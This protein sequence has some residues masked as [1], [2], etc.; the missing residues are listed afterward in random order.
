M[1]LLFVD[2]EEMVLRGIENG[3]VFGPDD[4]EADFVTSAELAYAAM[5]ATAY[6][7]LVTDMKMPALT[8]ADV[9]EFAMANRPSMMRIVLSGEIDP[10]LAVRA[11]PLTHQFVSKPCDPDDLFAIIEDAYGRAQQLEEGTVRDALSRLDR[12]PSQPELFCKIRECIDRSAGAGAVAQ[13]IETDLAVAAAVLRTANS[14]FYGFRSPAVTV[15]EAVARL[16]SGT[17]S[18]I[19]LNAELSAWAPPEMTAAVELLNRH[20]AMVA[21]AVREM[22]PAEYS[23][24]S[25][26]ALLHDVGILVVLSQFPDEFKQ[27]RSVLMVHSAANELEERAMFGATHGEIGAYV[28]EMWNADPVIVSVAMHHHHPAEVDGRTRVILDAIAAADFV[29]H[30]GDEPPL[31]VPAELI[32]EAERVFEVET[33]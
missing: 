24:A 18:G 14:A 17:I 22:L 29:S 16:G 3:L 9:L 25:L 6:D 1:R 27:L 23:E 4:W 20:S 30:G 10:D 7:V 33:V 12:L 8:G 2:D 21:E 5:E 19:V 28:L 11:I 13:V 32:L 26:A 31:G 15:K